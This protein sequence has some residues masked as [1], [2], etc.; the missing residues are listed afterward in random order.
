MEPCEERGW[1]E[2]EGR[3]SIEVPSCA[4]WIEVETEQSGMS[5]L[6]IRISNET[7]N[8]FQCMTARLCFR[9]NFNAD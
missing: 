9:I 6:K 7:E 4:F 2:A 1:P 5:T 3:R 8:Q